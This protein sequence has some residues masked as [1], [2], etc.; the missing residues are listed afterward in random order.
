[1][2][3]TLADG[4]RELADAEQLDPIRSRSTGRDLQHVRVTFT[5]RGEDLDE[6]IS[7]ELVAASNDEPLAGEDD[8]LWAVGSWN[9]YN[10]PSDGP[11]VTEYTVEL[12]EVER[13]QVDRV[14]FLGLDLDVEEYAEE[15]GSAQFAFTMMFTT[16]GDEIRTFEQ[17]FL[18]QLRG[19]ADRYFDVRRI[20]V[21]DTPR[22]FRFGSVVWEQA[23]PGAKR[24]VATLVED[25]GVGADGAEQFLSFGEPELSNTGTLALQ[26]HAMLRRLLSDLTSA[27]V[28]PEGAAAEYLKLTGHEHQLLLRKTSDAKRYMG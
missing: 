16:R 10:P 22:R 3:I 21:D 7:R 9:C 25:E 18:N 12:R 17:G 19:E 14:A 5:V 11:V 8:L 28:L 26:H 24:W 4:E 6:H 1:M 13:I 15:A 23:G 27:G 2:K 20:G